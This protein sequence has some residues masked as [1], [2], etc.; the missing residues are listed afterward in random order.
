MATKSFLGRGLQFPLG[1]NAVGGVATS[2]GPENIEQSIRVIVGTAVGERVMRPLFGSRVHDFVF[3]P[4]SEATA[5]LVA[6]YVR[7]ALMKY[8]PRITD[9]RVSAAPDDKREN[10]MAVSVKYTVRSTNVDYNLVYPFY[11]RR[12][13]DL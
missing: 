3:H 6:F 12:E 9:I 11:L 4:N 5:G 13:Q 8:E 1:V 2:D 7:E 10:V